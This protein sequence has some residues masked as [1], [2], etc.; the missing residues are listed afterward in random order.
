MEDAIKDPDN[1]LHSYTLDEGMKQFEI[2]FRIR[3][4][5]QCLPNFFLI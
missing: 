3:R 4:R 2:S 1:P 5:Q